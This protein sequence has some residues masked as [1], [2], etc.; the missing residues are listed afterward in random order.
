[1]PVVDPGMGHS[2]KAFLE[3]AALDL[4]NWHIMPEYNLA[5]RFLV[6]SG[7]ARHITFEITES[8]H[9]VPAHQFRYDLRSNTIFLPPS[10]PVDHP[11]IEA[12]RML[13]GVPDQLARVIATLVHDDPTFLQGVESGIAVGQSR[14]KA[15]GPS[16]QVQGHVADQ[17]QGYIGPVT[18]A[19]SDIVRHLTSHWFGGR[20]VDWD[21]SR[22]FACAFF[23]S[24]TLVVGQATVYS[25]RFPEWFSQEIRPFGPRPG[26]IT[27]LVNL[28]SL[29][30]L[31]TVLAICFAG[32]AAAVDQ[33]HGPV[34]LFFGGFLVPYLVLTLLK[35]LNA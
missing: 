34:R 23:G 25:A 14:L 2:L 8:T 21:F 32:M 28:P 15:N 19:F 22:R 7:P 26:D 13:P 27:L 5:F 9:S 10:R 35:W 6:G 11:E 1:M 4:N 18:H 20:Q 12:H 16:G 33:Q 24:A 31:M 29:L 17:V 3:K 30:G